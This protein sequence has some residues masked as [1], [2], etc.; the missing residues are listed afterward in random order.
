MTRETRT[1][2]L[3]TAIVLAAADVTLVWVAWV[4]VAVPC[5]AP[6]VSVEDQG[7]W[8][9]IEA[10]PSPACPERIA[11]HINDSSRIVLVYKP[12][13]AQTFCFNAP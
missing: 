3:L 1:V 5:G 10:L 2:G 11:I 8:G 6:S 13:Q 9:W 12:G 4:L 7:E